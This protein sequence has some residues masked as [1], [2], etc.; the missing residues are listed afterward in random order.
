MANSQWLK[1]IHRMKRFSI[2]GKK[3]PKA[4]ARRPETVPGFQELKRQASQ[5]FDKPKFKHTDPGKRLVSDILEEFAEPL[6]RD[7]PPYETEKKIL[8]FCFFVWNISLLPVNKQEKELNG[9]LQAMGVHGGEDEKML[10]EQIQFLMLRK[11]ALFS[12]YKMF[13]YGWELTESP[14]G[15]HHL[16][17]SY[18]EGQY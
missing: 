18:N 15:L 12:E 14:D 17:V 8:S 6:C 5:I 3:P 9:M 7:A 1:K 13:I 2:G 16:S 10:R 4:K 11:K